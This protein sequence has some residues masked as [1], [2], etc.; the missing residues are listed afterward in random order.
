MLIDWFTI[1]A[2]V[3]NF[4]M[5]VWLMRRYLYQPILHAIDERE[6]RIA[7]RLADAERKETDAQKEGDEYKRKNKDFEEERARLLAQATEVARKER[8]RLLAEAR[9]AAAELSLKQQEAL[10]IQEQ[11]AQQEIIRRIQK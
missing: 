1:I 2:Q 7:A 8:E 4:L 10:R 6:K 5:L 3:L 9:K 11:N